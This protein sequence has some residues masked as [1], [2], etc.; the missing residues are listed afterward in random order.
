MFTMH[1]ERIDSVRLFC[2]LLIVVAHVW[3]FMY[4]SRGG[5]LC[6]FV[7][8]SVALTAM[9]ALFI[10]SGYL[11]FRNYDS[12]GYKG[13]ILSR[14]L[15]LGV[16]L[17]IWN[18]IYIALYNL[19]GIVSPSAKE[20]AM[21]LGV[22][23]VSGI[24]SQL[25]PSC[26]LAIG[27]FWYVRAVLI[28]SVAAPVYRWLYNHIHWSI[29]LFVC[30]IVTIGMDNIIDSHYPMYGASLFVLGGLLA[31]KRI[32]LVDWFS[33]M[34]KVL[35][36]V[37]ISVLALGF[38]RNIYADDMSEPYGI[39]KFASMLVIW[40]CADYIHMLLNSRWVLS[41]MMPA[42]FMVYAAHMF[43]AQITLHSVGKS[44]CGVH[45]GLVPMGLV[46]VTVCFCLT[47]L[48]CVVM[49]HLLN[50]ICPKALAILDGKM[51]LRRRK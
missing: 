43:F 19:T 2:N 25:D 49:W 48:M 18:G 1:D 5:W 6:Y 31:H 16:P 50:I 23:T 12:V 8:R 24:L 33:K 28:L 41:Y 21:R 29:L 30:L 15:R 35:I 40:C 37:G 26:K 47:V 36:P 20:T 38:I 13:K 45:L 14:I 22:N 3:P 7:C 51:G 17:L 39:I 44:I 34:R 42:G 4:I 11:L 10:L 32:D 46:S 27:P 9:P